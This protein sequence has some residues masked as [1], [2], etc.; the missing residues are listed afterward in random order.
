MISSR[1]TTGPLTAPAEAV[2]AAALAMVAL[3][4][5]ATIASAQ[6]P[7][8]GT[9]ITASSGDASGENSLP[10]DFSI[11]AEDVLS[12]LVWREKDL[13][14]D[15]AVRPDGYITLP[16]VN[17]VLA[18]GRTPAQLRDHL[19]QIL[20]AHIKEPN[21][22]VVVREIKSRKVF[23]T[24]KIV[25]PGAYPLL[26]PMRVMDLIAVAGGL[27]PAADGAHLSVLRNDKGARISLPIDYTQLVRG[28]RVWQDVLLR[29]GDTIVVP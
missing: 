22:T 29:P 20:R 27:T 28:Q 17:D 9:T 26:S 24:G 3:V 16:L 14:L 2:L 15:V 11:G 5:C 18:A 21:V 19:Q 23:I 1:R 4:L 8:P 12:V 10:A 6:Q 13:S 25:R 7:A